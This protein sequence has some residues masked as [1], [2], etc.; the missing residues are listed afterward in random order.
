MIK[1][2]HK[3][4]L[5]SSFYVKNEKMTWFF[6]DHMAGVQKNYKGIL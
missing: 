3:K 5:K 4:V 1:T 6:I 2:N